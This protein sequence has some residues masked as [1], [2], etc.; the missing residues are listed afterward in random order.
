MSAADELRPDVGFP[1]ALACF[2]FGVAAF[3]R[4]LSR[5]WVL[6]LAWATYTALALPMVV[7][8]YGSLDAALSHNPLA[9]GHWGQV[10]LAEHDRVFPGL[11]RVSAWLPLL[12]A[13]V[14]T[15]LAPGLVRCVHGAPRSRGLGALLAESGRLLPRSLRSLLPALVLLILWTWLW[16]A[17]IDPFLLGLDWTNADA[18]RAFR[19][20]LASKLVAGI[21]VFKVL[22]LRRL[23]LARLVVEDRRSATWAWLWALG[24]YAR[25]PLRTW[26]A[27]LGLLLVWVVVVSAGSTA[28]DLLE[29]HFFEQATRPLLFL[30]ATQ[31]VAVL[32]CAVTLAGFLVA[33]RLVSIDAA[34]RAG[35]EVP[36]AEVTPVAARRGRVASP[37]PRDEAGI[38][39]DESREV[40]AWAEGGAS[41]AT[42]GERIDATKDYGTTP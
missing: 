21:G 28:L 6:L 15:L 23:A 26:A 1:G 12:S 11:G 22:M 20:G 33:G 8:L 37:A 25:H 4:A 14:M 10:L 30:V 3:F 7:P 41:H 29:A 19:V 16:K 39:D 32:L 5:P 17:F 42:P 9:Q 27:Y 35:P 34:L 40:M 18:D 38:Q 24:W 36:V 13:L 2:G 31:V